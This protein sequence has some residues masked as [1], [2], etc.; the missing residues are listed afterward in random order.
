MV[1]AK[2]IMGI[3]IKRDRVQKKLFL[4]QKEYIQ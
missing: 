4:C 2:K 3:E 1:A